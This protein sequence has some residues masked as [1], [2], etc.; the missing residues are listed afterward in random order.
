MSTTS[1]TKTES[2]NKKT[3]SAAKKLLMIGIVMAVII[4]IVVVTLGIYINTGMRV[5]A[6]IT[7]NVNIVNDNANSITTTLNTFTNSKPA[8]NTNLEDTISSSKAIFSEG[9][10]FINQAKIEIVDAKNSLKPGF[11]DDTKE[12]YEES[13]KVFDKRLALM[14][15]T[16][17]TFTDLECIND[18]VSIIAVNFSTAG[19]KLSTT[20]IDV[21]KSAEIID[22]SVT[23]IDAATVANTSLDTCFTNSLQPFY[24]D[25]IKAAIA[26]DTN[27]YDDFSTGLKLLSTGVKGNSLSQINQANSQIQALADMQPTLFTNPDF[28]NLLNNEVF[29]TIS[30]SGNELDA[31]VDSLNKIA[32]RVGK[33]YII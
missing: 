4:L 14:D 3:T 31:Q 25:S 8:A 28:N 22:E 23:L 21:K 18:K 33:K 10:N 2:H 26:T 17:T 30:D 16:L 15:Q 1:T 27:Y 12:Y 29:K 7:D 5:K 32:D 6:N 24:T 9:K 19:T 11:N 13:K 20:T